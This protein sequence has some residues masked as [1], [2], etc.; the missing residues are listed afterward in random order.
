MF[1]KSF[2]KDGSGREALSKY[3]EWS[4]SPRCESGVVGRP[5]RSTA[6]GRKALPDGWE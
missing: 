2:L 6:S 4:V 5:F 1:G 3:Q